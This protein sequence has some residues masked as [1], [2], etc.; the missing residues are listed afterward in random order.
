MVKCL[1]YDESDD[2]I[3]IEDEFAPLGIAVSGVTGNDVYKRA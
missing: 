2:S 3:G 1:F